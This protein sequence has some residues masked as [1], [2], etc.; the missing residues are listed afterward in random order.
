MKCLRFYEFTQ[1]IVSVSAL[2]FLTLSF[3]SDIFS[4]LINKY[5]LQYRVFSRD[6]T[7]FKIFPAKTPAAMLVS[8]RGL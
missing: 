3:A 1:D 4:V 2:A 6:V 7:K 5:L 8:L